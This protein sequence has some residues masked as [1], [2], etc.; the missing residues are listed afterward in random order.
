MRIE[1]LKQYIKEEPDNPFNRYALALE[2]IK[3][4]DD[5]K[6]LELFNYVYTHHSD[7]LPNYYHFGSLLIKLMNIDQAQIILKKGITLAIKQND[8]RTKSELSGLLEETEDL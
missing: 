1:L 2:F 7:Y 6:A 5:E 3:T 4:R 8:N